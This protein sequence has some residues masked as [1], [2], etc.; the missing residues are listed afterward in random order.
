MSIISSFMTLI[1]V[2]T[3]GAVVAYE[4]HCAFDRLSR[5]AR[6]RKLPGEKHRTGPKE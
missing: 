1:N 4:A 2:G 3:L 6:S 5:H